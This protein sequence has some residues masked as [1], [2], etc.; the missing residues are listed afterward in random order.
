MTSEAFDRALACFDR[1]QTTC[2][3]ASA[4]QW[5]DLLR[6]HPAEAP[7]LRDLLALRQYLQQE[8]AM[9]TPIECPLD[10]AMVQR[11]L[12]HA[13]LLLQQHLMKPFP[14]S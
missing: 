12:N 10:E 7:H 8:R 2:P 1:F 14:S 4:A 9:P 5:R 13:L 3:Q 6:R 11:T